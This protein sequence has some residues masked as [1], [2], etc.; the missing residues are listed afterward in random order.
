MEYNSK[1]SFDIN[2]RV[3]LL[4]MS[5]YEDSLYR[6]YNRLLLIVKPGI[7]PDVVVY[8]HNGSSN[9]TNNNSFYDC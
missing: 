6:R 1:G 3:F 8:F 7:I 2:Q 5:R 4:H 9:A